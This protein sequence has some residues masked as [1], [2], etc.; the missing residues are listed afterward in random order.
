MRYRDLPDD[1]QV[2]VLRPVARAAA[3]AFGLE[4]ARMEL[5]A[6]EYNTTFRVDTA[7]GTRYALRV[8]TNSHSTREHVVA[9]QSWQRAIAAE[10]EVLV[11]EPLRTSE[12]GWFVELEAE[13]V[14]R[15][16]LVT[17]ASWL[18]GSHLLQVDVPIA[19]ELGRAMAR[20][21][22]QAVGWALP[23]GAALPPLDTPLFGDEDLLDSAS[24]LSPHDREVLDR[25]RQQASAA[26]ASL[27]DGAAVRPIHADLHAGNL[28]WHEGRLAVFD[29]DD[30]GLGVPALDLAI[31]VFYL[32][33]EEPA[34]EEALRS[35]YADVTPLPDIEPPDFEALVASRQLL[36]AN[37]LLASSTAALRR[38]ADQYLVRAVGRLRHWF[39][40][41]TFTRAVPDG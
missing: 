39:D 37:S 14:E 31:T 33:G 40:T 21:H 17:A 25:A 26:F 8:G 12:G 11:A 13:T 16:L 41:G 34:L 1:E 7:D 20:L 10:T 6:H 24:G 35:G 5:A 28:K 2:E 3:E 30:C 15:P 9:Q 4:V 38:E 32:R 27:Y 29:F 23:A 36:L 19:R 22:E 18:A